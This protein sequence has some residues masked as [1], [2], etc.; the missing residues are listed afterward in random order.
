MLIYVILKSSV[1][2]KPQR[3]ERIELGNST[4]K[5]KLK[6]AKNSNFLLEIP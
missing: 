5:A 6:T 1:V 3:D 2:L 4:K